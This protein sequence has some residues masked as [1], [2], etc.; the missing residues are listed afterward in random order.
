MKA[1]KIQALRTSLV[2]LE[3]T[4]SY[5]GEALEKV[6]PQPEH[7]IERIESYRGIIKK[8]KEYALDLEGHLEAGRYQEVA[9]HA[10]LINGL[11]M[12]IYEDARGLANSTKE[13]AK[14]KA[15]TGRQ[16]LC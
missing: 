8:Q 14:A 10:K 5:A 12:M 7:L 11:T 3:R 1:E 9:R 2:E 16:L 13:D 4:I 6:E 15:P